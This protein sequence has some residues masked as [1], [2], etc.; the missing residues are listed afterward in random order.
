MHDPSA[1]TDIERIQDYFESIGLDDYTLKVNDAKVLHNAESLCRAIHADLAGRSEQLIAVKITQHNRS[2]GDSTHIGVHV[3]VSIPRP[4]HATTVSSKRRGKAVESVAEAE[5][6][7]S[8]EEPGSRYTPVIP[9][10]TEEA[11]S[12]IVVPRGDSNGSGDAGKVDQSKAEPT[13]KPRTP[14]ST[15][16]KNK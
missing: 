7:K 6:D 16:I 13:E 4:K 10:L 2:Y 15:R 14:P 1:G 5:G 9:G 8:G 11:E 12:R 3:T